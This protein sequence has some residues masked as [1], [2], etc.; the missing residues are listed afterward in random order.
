VLG[1]GL[2]GLARRIT[3][4]TRIPYADIPGFS[5]TRVE[6]HDGALIHGQLAG[7][8]VIALSGRFHVYEGHSAAQAAFPVRVVAALGA[9]VLVVSNA[10]GGV[11]RSFTPGTLMTIADHVNLTWR[12]A[13]AGPL[14]SGDQRFPDMSEPYDRALRE[15]LHG[16]ARRLGIPLEEGIYLG[17]LGPTYETPAEVRMIEQLGADAVGMS[18]VHEVLV[19]RALGLRVLGVSCITNAAA[20][21]GLEKIT[22]ADVMAATARASSSFERLIEG[23]VSGR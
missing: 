11:R 18:T 15:Q 6:G 9:P 22:H 7:A 12:S 16:V 20:G 2:S 4:A 1:S 8:E 13:L 23:W 19:A 17:L 5:P 21:L 10:A 14:V 3:H